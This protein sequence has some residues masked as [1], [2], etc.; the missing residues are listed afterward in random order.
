MEIHLLF[1][2]Q[3]TQDS[4]TSRKIYNLNTVRIRI[5]AGFFA[6]IDKLILKFIWEVKGLSR[7][8][9]TW[10]NKKNKNK[11]KQHTHKKSW[12]TPIFWFKAYYKAI[13]IKRLC[14]W[15]KDRCTDHWNRTIHPEIN[16]HVTVNWFP[17]VPTP[18]N[19]V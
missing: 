9:Q 19:G 17:R 14:Y 16:L 7:T 11:K 8:R 12:M 18:F 6:K 5:A 10:K 15:P 1:L 4:N 2:D 13:I 3:K